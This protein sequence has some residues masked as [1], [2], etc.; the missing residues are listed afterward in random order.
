MVKERSEQAM[1]LLLRKVS[2]NSIDRNEV[3][4]DQSIDIDDEE[5]SEADSDSD[6]EDLEDFRKTPEY[7]TLK[8]RECDRYNGTRRLTGR[9]PSWPMHF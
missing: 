4:P 3:D 1:E 9:E 8:L 2:S 7:D 5:D 6:W